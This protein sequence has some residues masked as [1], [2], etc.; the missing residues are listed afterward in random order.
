MRG[1]AAA[2][3]GGFLLAELLL[4]ALLF[5]TDGQEVRLLGHPLGGACTFWQQTHRPCPTCGM[6]R[7]VIFAVKGDLDRAAEMNPVGPIAV[8]GML[9]TGIGLLSLAGLQRLGR[10]GQARMMVAVLKTGL[11]TYAGITGVVWIGW[12]LRAVS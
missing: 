8:A 4:I 7:S 9:V 3:V 11:I 1:L 10:P 5:N 6:T 12:W 2:V